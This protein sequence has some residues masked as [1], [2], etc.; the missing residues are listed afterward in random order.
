M[1]E[2]SSRQPW[3]EV[4]AELKFVEFRLPGTFRETVANRNFTNEEIGRIVRC[5]ALDTDLFLTQK[6]EPEVFFYR[7]KLIENNKNR[8]RVAA[9][10]NKVSG[11]SLSSEM[12]A[13][14]NVASTITVMG[15]DTRSSDA[16]S[17]PQKIPSDQKEKTPP[18]VPLER[19]SPIPLEK[20]TVTRRGRKKRE[21]LAQCIQR[22][23]FDLVTG[24]VSDDTIDR[25]NNATASPVANGS[26]LDDKIP[27]QDIAND[28]RAAEE[29]ISQ[30]HDSRVDAAW[31][32]EKF[33]EFWSRYPRKVAKKDAFKAFSRLIK[34]QLDVDAFMK[35]ILASVEWWK[36]QQSWVKDGG[37]FIPYPASWINGGHWEDIKYN[38]QNGGAE[39]LNCGSES[40]DELIRR[41]QGG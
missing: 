10:R 23:L 26:R 6:I 2:K 27:V 25:Q 34:E 4:P 41:M 14:N 33:A 8:R 3:P 13:R 40:D 32:P 9:H 15:G 11:G 12:S 38:E 16:D 28:S 39:F 36:R 5:I 7:R 17:I 37:K 22:D 24:G 1:D 30:S 35:T 21:R 29:R 18:I 20:G 31:I 19:K